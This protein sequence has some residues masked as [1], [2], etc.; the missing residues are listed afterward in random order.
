MFRK[1]VIVWGLIVSAAAVALDLSATTAEACLGCGRGCGSG[2]GSCYG[3]Y[4]GSYYGGYSPGYGGC[5]GGC[6]RACASPCVSACGSYVTSYAPAP[7][8]YSQPVYAPVYRTYSG[9]PRAGE[10]VSVV[11]RTGATTTLSYP[12]YYQP[13]SPLRGGRY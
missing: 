13:L 7:A 11:R 12:V 10:P 6:C 4:Y 1:P 2:C 3:S 9:Y 8:V 5:G